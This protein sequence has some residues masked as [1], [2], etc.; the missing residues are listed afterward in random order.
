MAADCAHPSP[1]LIRV[2]LTDQGVDAIVTTCSACG[3]RVD[4][5]PLRPKDIEARRMAPPEEPVL[6][7]H[8]GAARETAVVLD[9]AAVLDKAPSNGKVKHVLATKKAPTLTIPPGAPAPSRRLETIC[10]IHG[11]YLL[12][13]STGPAKAHECVNSKWG[14]KRR[15]RAGGGRPG[16]CVGPC[17][18]VECHR[19]T[20]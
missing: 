8:V 13:C 7:R 6:V 10:S 4:Y 16:S 17:S 9:K 11:G 19:R 1:A 15:R 18:C 3:T 5:R 12:M 20:G 2:D 14:D